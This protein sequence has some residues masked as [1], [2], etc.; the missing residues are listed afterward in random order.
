MAFQ[1]K[2]HLYFRFIFVLERV[3]F[4]YVNQALGILCTGLGLIFVLYLQCFF[5]CVFFVFLSLFSLTK[6]TRAKEHPLNS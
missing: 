2:K 4:C 5:L 3:N 1:T 6:A